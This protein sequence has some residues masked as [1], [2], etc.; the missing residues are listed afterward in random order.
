ML[1]EFITEIYDFNCWGRDLILNTAEAITSSQFVQATNFPHTTIKRTLIHVLSAE[2]TYRIRCQMM[3]K[4]WLKEEQFPD[5]KSIREYWLNEEREMRKYLSHMADADLPELV[6]YQTS[7]G[8]EY[9]RT[10]QVILTQLFF[11]GMQ[12]R[13]ELAQM[14][15]EFGRSPGDIDYTV[16]RDSLSSAKVK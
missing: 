11:H 1:K 14:L 15:T 8:D 6:R 5:L 16:Y 4:S 12:H 10:R 2:Y 9:E 13:S 3:P 7:S